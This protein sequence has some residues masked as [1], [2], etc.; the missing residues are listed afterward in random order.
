MKTQTYINNLDE[1]DIIGELNF[2]YLNDKNDLGEFI[3]KHYRGHM[4]SINK[5]PLRNWFLYYIDDSGD[6]I[7]DELILL[8]DYKKLVVQKNVIYIKNGYLQKA[9]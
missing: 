6:N 9:S 7:Y 4:E 3:S 2:Y 5:I 1:V 8:E